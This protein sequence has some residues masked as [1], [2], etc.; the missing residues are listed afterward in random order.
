MEKVAVSLVKVYVGATALV[1]SR[2]ATKPVLTEELRVFGVKYKIPQFLFNKLVRLITS[3]VTCKVCVFCPN[4][5]LKSCIRRKSRRLF[6]GVRPPLRS[7]N[8]PRRDFR[9]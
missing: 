4:L 6:Q 7:V 9:Y 8:C 3:K 1:A 2:V 5:K